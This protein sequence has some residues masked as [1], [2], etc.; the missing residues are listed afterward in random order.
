M[1]VEREQS[2]ERDQVQLGLDWQRR[3]DDVERDQIQKS[4]ALIQGL[5]MAKSQ[6]AAKLQ[7]TERA[8]REQEVVLKAVTLERDQAVQALKMHGLP[9]PEAQ[10]CSV[11][12][13]QSAHAVILPLPDV[14]LVK[15]QEADLR[16][17]WTFGQQPQPF[18]GWG[19]S[20]RRSYMPPSRR[21]Q[22]DS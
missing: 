22:E 8:L 21:E 14:R 6:V 4:E 20:S 1:A 18:G 19:V 2:L 11:L 3:C 9:R 7:E 16:F 17:M 10:E 12:G 15:M 5:T 13:T